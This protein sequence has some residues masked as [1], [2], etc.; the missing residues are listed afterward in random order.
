[1][2]KNTLLVALKKTKLGW[3]LFVNGGAYAVGSQAYCIS[4]ANSLRSCKGGG[5]A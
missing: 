5:A 4:V 3:C 1:M 2:S